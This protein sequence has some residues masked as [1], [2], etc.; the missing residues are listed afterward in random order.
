MNSWPRRTVLLADDTYATV[1]QLYLAMPYVTRQG[2]KFTSLVL[3][4]FD[5]CGPARLEREAGPL[6][7]QVI[8]LRWHPGKYWR[9]IVTITAIEPSEQVEMM[10]LASLGY[11]GRVLPPELRPL[12]LPTGDPRPD[13][14]WCGR[15]LRQAKED[16]CDHCDASDRAAHARYSIDQPSSPG[17]PEPFVALRDFG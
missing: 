17:P 16:V 9:F 14:P 3:E 10:R 1:A 15:P 2:R 12:L 7:N 11:W 8:I 4:G 13:C 5:Y 6:L